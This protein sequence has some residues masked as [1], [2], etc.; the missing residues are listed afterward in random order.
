M[1]EKHYLLLTP[2]PLTTTKTVKEV[3]LYDW[4]T[5]DAEYNTMV[6]EVR[7]RLVSL[8][9]RKTEPY[10][11]ILMQ[12]SG[13]FSVES[14]I[15]S[16]I[17]KNG[18]L[19][20]CTNG[21]YGKRI[22]QMAE[23][24][25]IDVIVSQTEEWEPTNLVEVEKLLQQDGAITHVAIVHCETT[26]GIINPIVDVCRLG[27]QYGKVTIVDAMSSFGGIEMDVADLQIDFMISS[28]NKCIQGV[29]GFG[30][31]I[32][33]RDE[34]VKCK[35][36][37]RSLSLDLYDQWETM[38]EQNGKWRFTSP[39]HI[40]RAFYQA[41]LELEE[42]GGIKVRNTRYRNNQ[43]TLVNR[44]REV[45]FQS[46][47]DERYQSPIITSFIYPEEG[48]EFNTLYSVLKEHGFVIY[49]GKI[50]KVDTFRIGNI[51]DV[52]EDDIN[53]LVDSIAKGVVIG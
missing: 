38:E 10:T 47:V 31:V 1:S 11:T 43:R 12:G 39:T 50:S 2:G 37:A 34:L 27:K 44:M 28:A 35:G 9:T 53:R 3:M 41:L 13:T 36:Q 14:V 40:V 17:P 6:Q 15:G 42:E 7:N 5:W 45:G 48:F 26:T 22:V 4:C 19:L 51:G 23:M 46:L 33:K 16:V 20:I 49:P 25:Q 18:K 30:F 24:L 21:A 29:P 32:A 8:A 52:H